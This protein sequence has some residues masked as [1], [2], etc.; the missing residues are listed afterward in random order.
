VPHKI[1]INKLK[2][3]NFSDFTPS[4]ILL[5]VLSIFVPKSPEELINQSISFNKEIFVSDIFLKIPY[6]KCIFKEGGIIDPTFVCVTCLLL[7][8]NIF[9]PR[10]SVC[11]VGA[12]SCRVELS[13]DGS[14]R[15]RKESGS[16]GSRTLEIS[17]ITTR[18]VNLRRIDTMIVHRRH[19]AS[20]AA[21][22][23]WNR[24]RFSSR[25]A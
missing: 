8:A 11:S 14:V 23:P 25:R 3:S 7:T 13:G 9:P 2:A 20:L 19:D 6:M 18:T 1:S 12:P 21:H 16:R 4:R 22:P 15:G 24:R 10:Y 17:F 5:R